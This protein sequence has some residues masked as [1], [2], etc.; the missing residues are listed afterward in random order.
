MHEKYVAGVGSN[1][2][3][4]NCAQKLQRLSSM[5]S[6]FPEKVESGAAALQDCA[7]ETYLHVY[8]QE[9]PMKYDI[10]HRVDTTSFQFCHPHPTKMI[11]FRVIYEKS[12]RLSKL[13]NRIIR[14]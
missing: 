3:R 6:I 5:Q 11:I 13:Q 4:Q 7:S 9:N 8:E 2:I 12:F 10:K 14:R 1:L